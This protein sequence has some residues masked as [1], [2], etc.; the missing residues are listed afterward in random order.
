M[1]KEHDRL[2]IVTNQMETL[3]DELKQLEVKCARREVIA[4]QLV[5][6][7]KL[8]LAIRSGSDSAQEDR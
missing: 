1:D 6:L 5:R 8:Y 4:V 3:A 2:T 7:G